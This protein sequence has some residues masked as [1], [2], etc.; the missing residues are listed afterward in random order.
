MSNPD[1]RMYES[2]VAACAEAL[3]LQQL[4]QSEFDALR[5]QDLVGLAVPGEGQ[6]AGMAIHSGTTALAAQP[7]ASRTVSTVSRGSRR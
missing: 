7:L 2:L 5:V 3:R 1:I 6:W 4:L